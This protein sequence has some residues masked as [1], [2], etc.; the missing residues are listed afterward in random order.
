M[1]DE[2]REWEQQTRESAKAFASFVLYRDAGSSR[3]LEV[4][5]QKSAKSVPLLKRWSSLYGWVDRVDAYDRHMAA[6][7]QAERERAEAVEAQK[8]A[9][10]R[11]LQREREWKMSEALLERA[12]EMLTH[13]TTRE[14]YDDGKTVIEP[15]DWQL[16]DIPPFVNMASKIAR[17]ASEMETE[18]KTNDHPDA[19]AALDRLTSQ[20][21]RLAAQSAASGD[22]GGPDTPGD[23]SPSV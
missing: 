3:S 7:Q 20:L 21:A 10:R 14:R 4:V 19:S 13:P 17:L 9:E 8:W 2:R 5:R 16:R 6:I 12:A 22:V 11:S 23:G 15:A 1:S 18:R